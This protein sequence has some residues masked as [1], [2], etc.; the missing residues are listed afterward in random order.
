MTL[1]KGK[2]RGGLLHALGLGKRFKIAS[3]KTVDSQPMSQENY[4]GVPNQMIFK[5][6][7]ENVPSRK[8]SFEKPV[9]SENSDVRPGY[10]LPVPSLPSPSQH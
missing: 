6:I 7:H 8:T 2:G 3:W 10:F 9:R 5:A 1:P 4:S